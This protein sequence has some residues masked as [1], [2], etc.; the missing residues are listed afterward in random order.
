MKTT[1]DQLHRYVSGSFQ[2]VSHLQGKNMSTTASRGAVVNMGARNR[3][4]QRCE[5]HSSGLSTRS[6]MPTN[7]IRTG[8]KGSMYISRRTLAV[9]GKSANQA[10]FVHVST[11][12]RCLPYEWRTVKI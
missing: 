1:L 8:A 12:N 2:F 3:A 9:P 5:Y 10:V 6:H 4:Q 7:T 11:E